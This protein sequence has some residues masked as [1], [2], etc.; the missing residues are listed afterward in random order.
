MTTLQNIFSILTLTVLCS[1]NNSSTNKTE[2]IQ[3][4]SI[5]S[6]TIS[7]SNQTSALSTLANDE[8][9]VDTITTIK[10]NELSISISRL[11]IYDEDNKIAQIQKDTVEIYTELGETIEGQLISI[12]S[13]QL[14]GLTVEQ[15]YETSVT[16]M[17]EGPHCDLTEWKHYYSDWKLLQTNRNGQFICDKYSEKEYE[18][19][20]KISIDDL[21][22]KVK[23]QCGDEW[24]KLVEKVKTPTEYPSGVNISRYYLRVTGQRKD[25]GKTVTKLIVI[26]TPMGC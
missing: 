15:R 6:D 9:E 18:K 12:S 20:P 19:F 13:D 25:N 4:D 10:F 24:L 22:Q 21:K 2:A 5:V 14:T 1:C 8:V 23:E 11:I 3:K 7:I 16:I 26:E 17:N